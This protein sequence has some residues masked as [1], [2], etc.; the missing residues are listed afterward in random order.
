M[1]PEPIDEGMLR[2]AALLATMQRLVRE[3]DA[4]RAFALD[5][6]GF[7]ASSGLDAADVD[8]LVALGPRRLFLYRRH[9]RKTLGRGI[10][11]Q[12]PRTAAR[13][14]E[15]FQAWVDRWIEAES[16]RSHYFRDAAFEMVAWAS[17]RW[18]NDPAVPAF[19]GDLARHELAYF[20]AATAPP[21]AAE[22]GPA[23]EITLDRSVRFAGAVRLARYDHA[24]HR[25]DADEDAR[26]VP[27]HEATVLLLYRDAEHEVRVLELTP[28]AAAILDRLLGGE[29]LGAAVV[30]AATA[31]GHAVDGAVTQSTAILLEDLRARG[32]LLGGAP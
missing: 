29:P 17:P 32:A 7:L 13:L 26:D 23:A 27:A 11:K 15:A 10:K 3:P 21:D 24:V 5:P 28:L 16:P 22:A 4:E 2:Y 12:V 20:D 30:G 25:L 8:Q 19:L 31:A 9:V 6:P 18:A 14:G 1:S